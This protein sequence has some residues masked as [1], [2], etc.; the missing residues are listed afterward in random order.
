M[1][2]VAFI[3]VYGQSG[4]AYQKLLELENFI[5]KYKLEIVCLQETDI[6]QNTFLECNFIS[7]NFKVEYNNSKSGFGTCTLVKKDFCVT[8]VMKD[9][10]GRILSLD[11]DD[12]FTIVNIYFPSGTDHKSKTEREAV[13]DNLPNLLLYKKE[14][15]LIGG[16]FNCITE[17]QDSLIHQDQ[18]MSKC[19]KK[20]IKLYNLSDAYRKLYPNK[21]QFSRYYVWKGVN[22]ATRIDR[23]YSWGNLQ[24]SEASY[25]SLSFS[26]HLAHVLC[27]RSSHELYLKENPRKKSIYKIKHW[28]VK[29]LIFQENIRAEFDHWLEMKDQ[30]STIYFWEEVV[31]PGIKK[32]AIK[33]E[34]E[35]N[36]ERY[37]EL[38]AL[39]LKVDFHLCKL[40]EL[41]VQ[42]FAERL[43]NYEVAKQNLNEFYQKRAKV[44]IYQNRSEIFEMTD[45]TKIYHYESLNNYVKQ[46]NFDKIEVNNEIFEQKKDIESAINKDLEETLSKTHSVDKKK[47]DELFSFNVPK[48]SESENAL[49]TKDVSRSEL[50]KA[51]KKLRSKA[52]P[53]LDGIPSGLYVRMFDLFAPLLLEVFNDIIHGQPPPASMRTS[54]VQYL[55]KPKK[56]KSIK[57]SDKRKISILCN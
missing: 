47:F 56:A 20:I 14:S 15:G 53:G 54:I 43:T 51:L 4:L 6:S 30:F 48:I 28:L 10:D 27:F 11:I 24:A 17:K 7:R 39:Q 50:K 18:K 5:Q 42:T 45:V 52:S 35:L 38:Q 16:D 55:N 25:N 46:S 19:L 21:S 36:N 33:R 31:K 12:Q 40:K 9:C 13:I 3:N 49:L 8:N 23:C 2:K 1:I 44:I 32:V 34:K 26:D 29:D 22:G 37:Q 41:N 57:L